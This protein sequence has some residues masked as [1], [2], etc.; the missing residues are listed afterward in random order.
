MQYKEWLKDHIRKSK[1]PIVEYAVSCSLQPQDVVLTVELLHYDDKKLEG[2]PA[3][4]T[5]LVMGYLCGSSEKK[6]LY[7]ALVREARRRLRYD[8]KFV[9]LLEEAEAS[10][11]LFLKMFGGKIDALS[12]LLTMSFFAPHQAGQNIDRVRAL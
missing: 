1:Y 12:S 5:K 11:K 3:C 7:P 4:Q 9:G 2:I 10:E 6:S 8:F